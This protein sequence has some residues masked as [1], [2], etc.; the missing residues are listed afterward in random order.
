MDMQSIEVTGKTV[1][2]AKKQAAAKLGVD[3]SSLTVTVLEETKGLFGKGQVRIRAEAQSAEV[4]EAPKPAK[5]PAKEKAAP[6]EKAP[7]EEAPVA[8]KPAKTKP[9]PK[10]KRVAAA[11]E[12]PAPTAPEASDADAADVAEVEATQEDEDRIVAVVKSILESGNLEVT[13]SGSSRSGKYVN[14]ALDGRDVAHLV[15]KHGEV[16]N[17]LQ[18]LVN[19]IVTQQ[20]KN[21]VR[22]TIDGDNYRTKREE[23]LTKLATSIAKEVVKRGE[24]A[25]LDALPAFER[26]VVH[27]ALS[28]M[29]GVTTYSEGEE[30][31]R[32][33]VI[34]PA[35]A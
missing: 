7:V 23:A 31:N 35:E 4:A 3:A 16:L 5:K 13:I 25:V 28:G 24:E 14:V 29:E 17:A 6:V 9:A 8:E 33:V 32:R 12:S 11:E 2:D 27:K 34:A 10:G 18:Y 22:A 19:V 30:P 21:G 26:R 20:F 1:D 15:G